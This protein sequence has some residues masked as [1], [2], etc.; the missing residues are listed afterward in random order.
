MRM[1]L[2]Q[3][4]NRALVLSTWLD[5]PD[6]TRDFDAWLH[7]NGYGPDF[8]L[9]RGIIQDV[10]L[11]ERRELNAAHGRLKAA[12]LLPRIALTLNNKQTGKRLIA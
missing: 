10:T 7:A 12:G 6:S 1:A 5:I 4:V 9:R 3:V 2:Y 11:S 8:T